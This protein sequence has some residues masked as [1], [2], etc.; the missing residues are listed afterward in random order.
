MHGAVITRECTETSIG[1]L[2][3]NYQRIWKDSSPPPAPLLASF[4]SPPQHFGSGATNFFAC[5]HLFDHNRP[6]FHRHHRQ[7][8]V[9]LDGQLI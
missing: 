6:I 7:P 4:N 9:S 3:P 1:Y 8:D 2:Q 5:L